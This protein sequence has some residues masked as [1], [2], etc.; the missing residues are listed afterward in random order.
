VGDE[1]RARTVFMSLGY[2]YYELIRTRAADYN[3]VTGSWTGY[4]RTIK[5]KGIHQML[6]FLESGESLQYFEKFLDSDDCKDLRNPMLK[7]DLG[8]LSNMIIFAS[9]PENREAVQPKNWFGY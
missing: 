9:K 2:Y 6:K 1:D 8:A 7:G 4:H 3:H 5:L